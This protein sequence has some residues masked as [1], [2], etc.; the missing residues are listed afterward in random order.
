MRNPISFLSQGKRFFCPAWMLAGFML[1]GSILT[2]TGCQPTPSYQG[3]AKILIFPSPF[4]IPMMEARFIFLVDYLSR[5]TGWKI[6]MVAAPSK[7]DAFLRI[8]ET[9][10]AAFSFQNVYLYTI[11]AR[12]L[13][14]VPIVKTVSLDGRADFRGLVVCQDK[15]AIQSISD[16]RGKKILASSR[17]NVG[18]FIAQ[19][20]MLKGQGLDPDRDVTYEFGDD[21]EEILERMASGRAE[22]GFVREDV[23]EALKRAKGEMPR[24]K[25]IAATPYYPNHNIVSYPG[26]D[27]ELVQKVKEAL[28]KLNPQNPDQAFILQRLRI[29]GFAQTSASDYADFTNLLVL[30]GFL[31]PA[32]ASAPVTQTVV[33]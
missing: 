5:E 32:P 1:I 13:G 15:N 24:V 31:T 12:K 27:P 25:I 21:Q 3:K 16:L 22:V 28:L 4:S 17:Y 11:L 2:G 18:G 6:N 23:L 19:W 29:S 8:A 10:K 30:N 20:I 26:T 7:E 9:E 33:Q 14:V